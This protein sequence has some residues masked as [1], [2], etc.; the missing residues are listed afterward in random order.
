MLAT[1]AFSSL[2]YLEYL[3][4][5]IRAIDVTKKEV[6]VMEFV[7]VGVKRRALDLRDVL[8]ATQAVW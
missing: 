3:A 4:V 7:V 1:A 2:V 8:E 5:L 6:A